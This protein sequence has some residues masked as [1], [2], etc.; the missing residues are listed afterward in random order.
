MSSLGRWNVECSKGSCVHWARR[1]GCRATYWPAASGVQRA[2]RMGHGLHA[3]CSG[4]RSAEEAARSELQ[5]SKR[6]R[7]G[8]T[9]VSP[10]TSPL[11]CCSSPFR[12]RHLDALRA[13]LHS[14][15]RPSDDRR[16]DPVGFRSPPGRFRRAQARSHPLDHRHTFSLHRLLAA[17]SHAHDRLRSRQ[18]SQQP[19]PRARAPVQ[20]LSFCSSALLRNVRWAD[21][22]RHVWAHGAVSVAGL[23]VLA[24]GLRIASDGRISRW[25]K[26]TS[27]TS[28]TPSEDTRASTAT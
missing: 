18:C 7:G 23:C 17:S 21:S 20:P 9:K 2:K 27:R 22:A 26:R 15:C 28:S 11:S 16:T 5:G 6:P 14:P 1:D 10:P 4:L 13:S 19:A 12:H 3:T 8:K 25:M 24:G